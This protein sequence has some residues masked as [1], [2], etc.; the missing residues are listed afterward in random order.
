MCRE[1]VPCADFKAILTP[2]SEV[3]WNS[4]SSPNKKKSSG[5]Q[6]IILSGV[7]AEYP[8]HFAGQ[9]F[10]APVVPQWLLNN[11]VRVCWS[12]AAAVPQSKV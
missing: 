10:F 8:A 5:T 7:I 1:L 3:I 12:T 4:Y 11:E 2:F 6:G 9:K